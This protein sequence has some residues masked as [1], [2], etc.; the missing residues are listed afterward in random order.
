M[1][2]NKDTIRAISNYIN[3][4]NNSSYQFKN[5]N[6][7]K[8]VTKST[9]WQFCPQD[10]NKKTCLFDIKKD[11]EV[12]KEKNFNNINLKFIRLL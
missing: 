10:I 2:S 1:K 9:F 12:I 7:E 4:L 8:F 5:L 6:F 11:Y 3:M